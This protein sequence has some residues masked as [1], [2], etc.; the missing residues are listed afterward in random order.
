MLHSKLYTNVQQQG[1]LWASYYTLACRHDHRQAAPCVYLQ[2]CCQ[3]SAQE[4]LLDIHQTEM[5]N[6]EITLSELLLLTRLAQTPTFYWLVVIFASLMLHWHLTL[7]MA[8]FW[9]LYAPSSSA[10]HRCTESN[11]EYA[12]PSE[13]GLP[14]HPIYRSQRLCGL[15][16]EQ[17]QHRS[18]FTQGRLQQPMLQAPSKVLRHSNLKWLQLHTVWFLRCA[19]HSCP[20]F[21]RSH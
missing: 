17:A 13:Y 6:V 7:H 2:K 3:D 1:I 12:F 10:S 16:K 8:D 11:F 5:S 20:S 19:S 14:S 18:L 9:Q 15:Q 4:G 21:S